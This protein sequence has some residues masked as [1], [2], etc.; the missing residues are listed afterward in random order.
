MEDATKSLK[1][2]INNGIAKPGRRRDG[3]RVWAPSVGRFIFGVAL[4]GL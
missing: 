2:V 3:R 1:V 4:F